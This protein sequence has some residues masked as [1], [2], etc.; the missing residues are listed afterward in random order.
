MAFWASGSRAPRRHWSAIFCVVLYLCVCA[1]ACLSVSAVAPRAGFCSLTFQYDQAPTLL[2][3]FHAQKQ[4]SHRMFSFY[5]TSAQVC[6]TSLLCLCLCVVCVCVS[7]VWCALIVLCP[8]FAQ[9]PLYDKSVLVLGPPDPQFYH[10]GL[11]FSCNLFVVFRLSHP[12]IPRSGSGGS[13]ARLLGRADISYTNVIKMYGSASTPVPDVP[14][15]AR[16]QREPAIKP[17][18]LLPRMWF[19]HLGG[20]SS[21][22]VFCLLLRPPPSGPVL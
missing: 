8:L 2:D 21:L 10:N 6:V 15:L 22:V 14:G 20:L 16:Q 17:T 5:L 3:S 19:V 18:D 1:C 7:V 11:F 13:A 9:G 4:I 12:L